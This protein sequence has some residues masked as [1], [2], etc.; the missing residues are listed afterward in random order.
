MSTKE[1]LILKKHY[2]EIVNKDKSHFESSN[3]E[4]T[5]IGCVEEMIEKIPVDF[6]KKRD[7]LILDPCAGNG[8]FHFVIKNKLEKN[9]YSELD[10]KNTL[11]F[12]EPNPKRVEHCY[13]VFGENI[14]ITQEDYLKQNI[15]RKVDLVVANPPYAKITN[16]KR[17]AKNHTLV[18]DFI[19]KAL[20]DVKND[21]FILFICPNNWM[22]LADRNTLIEELTKYRFH[23]L[24][25][26]LAKKWFPKIGS[27]FTWFVLQKTKHKNEPF[28]VEGKF[29]K[30]IYSSK[31]LNQKRDYIPLYYTKE[32][33]KLLEK[34]LDK[35]EPKLLIETS[36]DLHEYTKRNLQKKE[37]DNEHKYRLIH[38][39]KQLRW[40]SRPHKFQNGWKLFITTT[41][42]YSVFIDNC[43]MTQSVAFIRCQNK[44][45]AETLKKKLQQPI[46]CFLNDIC[47][48]GN[49]NNIRIL[50][51]FSLS[52]DEND[53]SSLNK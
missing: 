3:D 23:Y 42:K 49:F 10:I 45:E 34:T 47:R 14:Q 27:S 9:G 20:K 53:I 46:Y 8:N 5:P 24:N 33:Q 22:S 28:L 12:N 43:G 36:S 38:T 41:D 51:R 26:G 21:G 31:P 39:K 48:W 1:Y 16:N 52:F 7:L 44:K 11:I 37:Q 30:K 15:K 50:Q 25:I 6:W 32:I 17:A 40:S 35:K 13:S 2:D 19:S 4:P 29:N 18:R